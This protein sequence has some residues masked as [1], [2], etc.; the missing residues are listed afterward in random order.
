MQET[1][2]LETS[3]TQASAS[4]TPHEY[5]RAIAR[6]QSGALAPQE[7]YQY[8]IAGIIAETKARARGSSLL[9]CPW[10]DESIPPSQIDPE[11]L[12]ALGITSLALHTGN[13]NA[14]SKHQDR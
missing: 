7:S 1:Q 5:Q 9:P 10:Q 13:L 3:P 12:I 8:K 6:F 11:I 14:S 2:N 4:M